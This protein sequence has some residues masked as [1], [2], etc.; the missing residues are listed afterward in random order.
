MANGD[1]NGSKMSGMVPSKSTVVGGGLGA[2]VAVIVCFVVEQFG[3]HVPG[4]VGAAIGAVAAAALGYF[5]SGGKRADMNG[6]SQ[7]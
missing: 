3:V 6:V 5:F 2:S 4:E 7:Q 1:A